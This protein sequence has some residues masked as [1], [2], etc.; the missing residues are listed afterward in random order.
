M[1][2]TELTETVNSLWNHAVS[3]RRL[4]VYETG[5][6][7]FKPFV[8]TNNSA[9]HMDPLSAL[10]EDVLCLYIAYCNTTLH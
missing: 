9:Q 2:L 3:A 8:L 4:S 10:S 5:L 6:K 1:E 7:S